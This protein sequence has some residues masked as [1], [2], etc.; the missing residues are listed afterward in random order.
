MAGYSFARDRKYIKKA[1]PINREGPVCPCYD[2][3]NY[4]STS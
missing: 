2:N 3:P 1:L 4:N